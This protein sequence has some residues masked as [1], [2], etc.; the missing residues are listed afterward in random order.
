MHLVPVALEKLCF[1]LLE[2]ALGRAD[3]VP[4]ALGAQQPEVR[5]ARHAAVHDPDAVGL[6]VERL[7]FPHDLVDGFRVVPVPF[8]GLEAEGN[9]FF[10]HDQRDTD[11]LAVEALIAG[12][13]PLGLGI[14]RGKPFKIG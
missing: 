5:L 4:A 2:Q 7:H 14:A 1:K 9:A 13:P 8:E 10:G 6:A 11:L 3:N 12:V